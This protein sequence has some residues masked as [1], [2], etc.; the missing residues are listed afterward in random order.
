VPREAYGA[1]MAGAGGEALIRFSP[2]PTTAGQVL[3]NR[4]RNA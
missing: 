1:K 3:K 4:E 2:K